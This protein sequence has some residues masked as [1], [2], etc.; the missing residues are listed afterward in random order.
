M[1]P[2]EQ[3]SYLYIPEPEVKLMAWV[4]EASKP[5]PYYAEIIDA[6]ANT[7]TALVAVKGWFFAR[8]VPFSALQS[9]ALKCGAE[10]LQAFGRPTTQ[11][12]PAWVQ[13]SLPL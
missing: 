4:H 1:N 9:V 8:P 13:Y 5:Y 2:N 11:H 3:I 12:A 10:V 7:Q 6:D